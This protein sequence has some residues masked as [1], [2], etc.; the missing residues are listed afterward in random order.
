MKFGWENL[1]LILTDD[2]DDIANI[3]EMDQN[4]R[5]SPSPFK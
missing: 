1:I 2:L 5:T 3:E 4:L